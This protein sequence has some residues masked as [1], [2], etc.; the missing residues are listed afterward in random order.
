MKAHIM[1]EWIRAAA[2]SGDKT[3]LELTNGSK[4]DMAVPRTYDHLVDATQ[5]EVDAFWN[6]DNT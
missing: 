6:D 3:Y 1:R 2:R 4:L 5:E